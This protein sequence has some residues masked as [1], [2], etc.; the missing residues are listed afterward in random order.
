MRNYNQI[1]FENLNKN[2][3]T[4]RLNTNKNIKIRINSEKKFIKSKRFKFTKNRR[5]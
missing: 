2:V 3:N 4:I 1:N 5:R